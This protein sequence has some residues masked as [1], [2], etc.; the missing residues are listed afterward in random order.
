MWLPSLWQV[1][2]ASTAALM[3]LFYRN[4]W[5]EKLPPLQALRKARTFSVARH[6][7]E[8]PKIAI[9]R[10]PRLDVIA[11][12]PD[13]RIQRSP[14]RIQKNVPRFVNGLALFCLAADDNDWLGARRWSCSC[15]GH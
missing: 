13:T 5:Q 8:I 7:E 4:L 6:P 11:K 14:N 15:A 2:D 1:E 9:A 3:T 12:A 10:G